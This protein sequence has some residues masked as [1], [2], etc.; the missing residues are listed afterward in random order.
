MVRPRF[1]LTFSHDVSAESR[2]V[3]SDGVGTREGTGQ[4]D[5][6]VSVN[7]RLDWLHCEANPER[8]RTAYRLNVESVDVRLLK[9]DA[10]EEL[11][12]EANVSRAHA[13]PND[14]H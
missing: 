2:D 9:A 4:T 1:A 8:I 13:V 12:N 11:P 7:A 14:V 5:K 10:H 6:N 3:D